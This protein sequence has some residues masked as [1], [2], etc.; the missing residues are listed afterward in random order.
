VGLGIGCLLFNLSL[1]AALPL[2]ALV[3]TLATLIACGGMYLTRRVTIRG[4][5][6][7]GMLLPAVANALLV[8][9]E[10]S[11]YVGGGFWFNAACVAIGE[12]AVLLSLGSILYYAIRTRHLENKLFG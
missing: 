7:L 12:A 5:P 4:Y 8:G 2:D 6:I 3:G 11:V 10:L 9:W 1:S